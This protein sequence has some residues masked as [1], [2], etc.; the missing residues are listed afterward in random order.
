MRK[1]LVF[2]LLLTFTQGVFA[3]ESSKLHFGAGVLT[4]NETSVNL[5]IETGYDW[6][7]FRVE[8][9]AFTKGETDEWMN[10]RGTLSYR[11]FADKPYILESGISGGY[12][13][14][15]APNKFY[16]TFNKVNGKK[17]LW[18]Y[19][20]RE[21]LDVS[22]SFSARLLGFQSNVIVPV[23]YFHNNVKPRFLWTFGY[24]FEL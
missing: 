10:A 16:K 17:F 18:E 19:N 2:L 7:M 4:T 9:F 5:A 3:L 12:L 22:L 23:V 8:G 13:Y 11:F 14:A 15:K 24:I 1:V 6:A 21:Y 20:L